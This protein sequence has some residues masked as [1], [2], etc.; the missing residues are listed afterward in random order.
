MKRSN[1]ITIAIIIFFTIIILIIVGREIAG[2]YFNKK[3]SK[4]PPPGVVVEIIKSK[5]F[6]Q[7]LESYCTS[8]SNKTESYRIKKNELLEEID[9]NR[10]IKKGNII[11]KLKS[12]NIIAPFSGILGKRGISESTLGSENSI[13]LT[14]DDTST[15]FCDLKIPEIYAGVIKKDLNLQAKF[16]AYKNNKYE[17]SIIPIHFFKF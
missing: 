17:Y 5:K 3:F 10:K 16:A 13:I 4:R 7:T 12:A 6:S 15:I 1:K 8:L 14:L 11:A 2:L 9:F